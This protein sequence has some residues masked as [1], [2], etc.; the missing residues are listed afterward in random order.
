MAVADMLQPK[1]ADRSGIEDPAREPPAI[2]EVLR[3]I[4]KRPAQPGRQRNCKA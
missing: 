1:L 2:E 4:A 3:P